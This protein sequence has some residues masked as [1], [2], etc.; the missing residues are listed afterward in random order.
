MKP[1]L[2]ETE[3]KFSRARTKLLV[4]REFVFWS[5][6][7]M[8]LQPIQV[9][10]DDPMW[11]DGTPTMA[12]DGQKIYYSK[13]FVDETPL[14]ELIGVIAHEAAHVALG[15]HLRRQQREPIA[16]NV[17]ADLALNPVI[18]DAGISLPKTTCKHCKQVLNYGEKPPKKGTF[19]KD[20][21]GRETTQVHEWVGGILYDE[22]FKGK[23]AEEIYSILPINYIPVG[24]GFGMGGIIDHPSRGKGK[25][26]EERTK[27]DREWE[28]VI[29]HAALTAKGQGYLPGQFEYLLEPV[30]VK[31]DLHSMLRHM[32][33]VSKEDDY[34]W[35]RPN[36]RHVW[37]NLYLPSQKTESVGDV[38]VG[39]DTSG[40]VSEKDLARF[41]G[42][43]NVV[44]SD[45]RPKKT[46]LVQC[47]AAV[48]NVQEFGPGQLLPTKIGIKGRGGTDMRPFFEWVKKEN[49][50]IS[51][52]IICSDFL[53][54][55]ECFGEPQKYSTLW[56][57]CTR[58]V[59]APWG[60]T[61]RLE[62]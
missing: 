62:D 53:M 18:I 21:G 8:Y 31:L 45:L 54:S 14:V 49:K 2:Q 41:V 27:A 50:N 46:Y 26:Q 59:K 58:D 15:H 29:R 30:E 40:S 16:W 22:K 13:K 10:D 24:S 17:A 42:V 43:V 25:T 32:V 12:T 57:T 48:S 47:D 5:T 55:V 20:V 35:S 52:A 28:I 23:I 37:Q 3:T 56:V 11:R 61:A 19:C 4:K 51:C 36:R 33:A 34:T 39:V 7:A 44:L 60:Q 6:I 9:R 1:D 38:M